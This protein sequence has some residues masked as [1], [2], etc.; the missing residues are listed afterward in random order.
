MEFNVR[1]VLPE[2]A[3]LAIVLAL[4]LKSVPKSSKRRENSASVLPPAAGLG[5]AAAGLGLGAAGL[6]LGAGGVMFGGS[7]QIDGL[8]QFF[9]LAVALGFAI[10]VLNASSQPTRE[11]EKRADYFLLLALSAL[12]LMCLASAVELITIYLALELSSYSLYALIPL[13]G[14]EPRAAEAG[15][16]Y[17]LFGAAAAAL[18]IA[19]GEAVAVSAGDRSGRIKVRLSEFIHPEAAFTVTGFGR[20]LPPESRALG[21]GL[22]ANRLMPGGLDI[23]D[24]SGGG[25]ALQE[26][27]ITIRRL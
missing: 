10:A 23:G 5:L 25:L 27:E 15:V 4:F 16:K 22:A 7:Y 24:P 19:D 21:H 20:T 6:G 3:Q 8:S 9:K 14:R 1:M 11:P 2:I 26:H 12:G 17:I 13:R 18:G